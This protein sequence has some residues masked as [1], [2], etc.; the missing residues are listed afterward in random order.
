MHNAG[1]RRRH[2]WGLTALAGILCLAMYYLVCSCV[3]W[4]AYDFGALI[5]GGYFSSRYAVVNVLEMG[6]IVAVLTTVAWVWAAHTIH[7]S[8]RIRLLWGAAWRTLTVLLL[9]SVAVL[10]KRETWT[11]Q[12]GTN[13]SAMFVVHPPKLDTQGLCF[14]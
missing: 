7:E 1:Q 9:Y 14:C 12:Q 10:V 8:R 5:Q 3:L 2:D 6:L 4:W 11:P 13:D